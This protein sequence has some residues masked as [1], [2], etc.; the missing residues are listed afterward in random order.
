MP[1][2][3]CVGFGALGGCCPTIAKLASYYSTQW[4][5]PPPELG[6]LIAML[7]FAL[8]GGIVAIAVGSQEIKAAIIAGIAAPGIVTNIISGQNIAN[9]SPMYQTQH[10]AQENSTNDPFF[11]VRSSYAQSGAS[12]ANGT[13]S[14]E[15]GRRISIRT[16]TIPDRTPVFPF[17]YPPRL[18]VMVTVN[19]NGRKHRFT[20]GSLPIHQ[21]SQDIPLPPGAES[22]TL[23][24]QDFILESLDELTIT[25]RILPSF[26]GDFFWM[27]G[28]PRQYEI[29]IENIEPT[30]KTGASKQPRKNRDT[31]SSS[32]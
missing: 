28:I 19:V 11:G 21:G 30:Y 3:H 12:R 29:E 13:S 15:P 31:N 4:G 10:S 16:R 7:L 26:G 8:L 9:P 24:G 6:V 32:D 25:A 18:D 27:L 14:P 5:A 1:K 17:M 22:I 20:I 2:L 23:G